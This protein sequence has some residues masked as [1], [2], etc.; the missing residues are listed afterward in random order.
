M[1]WLCVAEAAALTITAQLMFF[2]NYHFAKLHQQWTFWMRYLPTQVARGDARRLSIMVR[3]VM[4]WNKFASTWSFF[5]G[6][7]MLGT[8][9]ALE[10]CLSSSLQ[11]Q[12]AST[13]SDLY[14]L[15]HKLRPSEEV[16]STVLHQAKTITRIQGIDQ[17]SEARTVSEKVWK[18]TEVNAQGEMTFEY[19]IE[20]VEMTQKNGEDKEIRY[21]S[22]KDKAAPPIYKKVAE[23]LG[24]PM[25]TVVINSRGQVLSR[26]D[27]KDAPELGMGDII[28]PL[29]EKALTVGEAWDVPRETRVKMPDGTHKTIK[30]REQYRL[31]KVQSGIATIAINSQPITPLDGPEVES[32]VMQQL[33]NGELKFDIDAGKM[34][35]KELNWDDSI[36]GF[37]GAES[38]LTYTA[39]YREDMKVQRVAR[40]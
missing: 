29:P 28:L 17:A 34:L 37:S 26:S 12:D 8:I 5:H 10:L 27:N 13:A 23:S 4:A 16:Y 30:I 35:S 33:S 19:R 36:V 6:A 22:R 14:L 11:A 3:N 32:Q 9:A 20:H 25:S 18:V 38:Q 2:S 24:K 31:K 40:K 7:I 1:G 39:R 21:D 15:R